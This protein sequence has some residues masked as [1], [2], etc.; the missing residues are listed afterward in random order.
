VAGHL[1]ASAKQVAAVARRSATALR[2]QGE[3]ASLLMMRPGEYKGFE[4]RS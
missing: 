2:E 4:R 3:W 1:W